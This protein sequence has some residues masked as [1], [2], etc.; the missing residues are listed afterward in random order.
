MI[1]YYAKN[2][3]E[4]SRYALETV[5]EPAEL[6]LLAIQNPEGFHADGADMALL[7]FEI[8]DKNGKRCPLDNRIVKFTLKGEGEWR[9]GIAQGK[10]NYILSTELPVECG[11][12]RALVRS[13]TR[14]G[15]IIIEAKAEGLPTATLVL[16]TIPVDVKNGMS[17]Y[18]PQLSLKGNLDRGETP[19]TPSY[20]D[21]KREVPILSA[22]AGANQED[23]QLSYDDNEETAWGNNGQLNTAWIT[24]TL[25][26]ESQIDDICLKLGGFRRNPPNFKQISSI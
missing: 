8:V 22:V 17:G 5:E 13:T 11:I 23:V 16:K 1:F 12:N 3:K 21:T 6:K 9:G 10:D 20:K 25:A 18:I 15:K 26:R 7:Q 4:L 14:A 19:L 24:Y 2:G